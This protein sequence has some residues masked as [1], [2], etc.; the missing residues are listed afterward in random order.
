MTGVNTARVMTIYLVHLTKYPILTVFQ[1][2]YSTTTDRVQGV[3]GMLDILDIFKKNLNTVSRWNTDK[4]PNT[5]TT[6]LIRVTTDVITHISKETMG[7]INVE[8]LIKVIFKSTLGNLPN[9]KPPNASTFV[10]KVI[11]LCAER[12]V[13]KM[14]TEV[15]KHNG[16]TQF[17][18]IVEESIKD[19]IVLLLPYSDMI[20][21][22]LHPPHQKHHSEDSHSIG[23]YVA[24]PSKNLRQHG[25]GFDDLGPAARQMLHVTD[26]TPRATFSTRHVLGDVR[27]GAHESR[28]ETGEEKTKT[29]KNTGIFGGDHRSISDTVAD[30]EQGVPVEI[31]KSWSGGAT[32]VV[33]TYGTL[34]LNQLD[35]SQSG[36]S[37]NSGPRR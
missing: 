12:L 31:T 37:R 16:L 32:R 23:P 27:C 25:A 19:A 28:G 17:I 1:R 22:I 10:Y 18:T 15:D 21:D 26:P 33:E 13:C 8:D 11:V 2:L 35:T 7:K 36:G 5:D 6:K 20:E 3:N 14:T 30:I 9:Q 4:V 24:E 34:N 29:P